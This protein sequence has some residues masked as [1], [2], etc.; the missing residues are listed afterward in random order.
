MV[1]KLINSMKMHDHWFAE[2][3]SSVLLIAV[4]IYAFI[5]PD[6]FVIQQSFI[7]GFLEFLPFDL[8]KWLFIAFGLMQAF[9]LRYES[10]FGRGIAAFLASSLLIWGT[11]NIAV[12]GQWHFSL[13]AWGI[14][15]VIN[16]YA[17]YRIARGI[18]KHYELL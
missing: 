14:F 16:L 6:H 13:V 15:A 1:K 18:E 4:G 17:L 9:S 8:W 12:Y 2:W 3:W 10:L 5:T 11:L 7:D